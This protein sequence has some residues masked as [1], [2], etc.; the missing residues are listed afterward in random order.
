MQAISSLTGY[1]FNWIPNIKETNFTT[2]PLH[3]DL[4]DVG[5]IAQEVDNVWKQLNISIPNPVEKWD[6]GYMRV[7]YRSLIPILIAATKEL[8]T[9]VRDLSSKLNN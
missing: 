7:K 6:D 9:Q 8:S 3:D 5:V 2:E 4:S 1:K